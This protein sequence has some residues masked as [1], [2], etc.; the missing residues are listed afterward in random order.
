ELAQ[1]AIYI[2]GGG[3]KHL[4]FHNASGEEVGLVYASDD[5]TLHLRAGQG[6]SVD[7]QSDGHVTV[8]GYLGAT[9][10]IYS[11]R[12]ISSAGL[13]QAGNGLYDTPGVRVYSPNNIPPQQDLSPYATQS[14]VAANFLQAG[15]RLASVGTANNGNNN[16]AFAYAPNGAMVTAVQQKSDY[17]SIQYRYVQYDINGNW[18]TAWV[19]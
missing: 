14:W 2:R 13:I 19:A 1:N 6:P 9:Q 17:T 12:N 15:I 3:N 5:K 16:D 8:N 7:I 11:G 4:W 10:D 18:I